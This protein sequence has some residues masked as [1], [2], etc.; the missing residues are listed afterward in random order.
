M[1]STATKF[2]GVR[3]LRGV[4]HQRKRSDAHVRTRISPAILGP[5]FEVDATSHGSVDPQEYV[6]GSL[7]EFRIFDE[8]S[9]PA[10]LIVG[11]PCE[12]CIGSPHVRI[13]YATLVRDVVIE[14]CRTT[15]FSRAS[16]E[17]N[18]VWP[19]EYASNGGH[20]MLVLRGPVRALWSN[21]WSIDLRLW[22]VTSI[23]RLTQS[24]RYVRVRAAHCG[25]PQ[26]PHVTSSA[27]VCTRPCE[28]TPPPPVAHVS[29]GNMH[30]E[31]SV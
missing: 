12:D 6:T 16:D 19:R 14:S 21:V 10:R 26:S 17:T 23:D 22:T 28:F 20:A 8:V 29:I 11:E 4:E 13:V 27:Y 30:S 24:F 25:D 7:T 15:W 5:L 31:S 2:V 18:G 1:K 3:L 9:T